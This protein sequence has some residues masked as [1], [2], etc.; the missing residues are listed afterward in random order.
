M[1]YLLHFDRPYKHARHYLGYTQAES[2]DARVERHRSRNGARLIKVIMQEG[3]GF[4]VART[5][6]GSRKLERR[7]K[8]R[9]G[10][11]RI[12]PVCKTEKERT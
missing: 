8:N 3:I 6:E 9:G 4:R 7:L 10:A 12:C 5:W 1:I 2:V 11:A